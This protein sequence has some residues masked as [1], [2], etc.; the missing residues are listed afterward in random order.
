MNTNITLN[1]TLIQTVTDSV[2]CDLI[3][4][5]ID[6]SSAYDLSHQNIDPIEIMDNVIFEGATF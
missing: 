5:G 2:Y 1:E 3:D 4:L 6:E